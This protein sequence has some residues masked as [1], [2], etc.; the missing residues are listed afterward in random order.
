MDKQQTT[1]ALA[2]VKTAFPTF[3]RDIPPEDILSLW[4]EIFS[5]DQFDLVAMAVKQYIRVEKYPPTIADIRSIMADISLSGHA[6]PADL[7]TEVDRLMKSGIA[8][9]SDREAYEKMSPG[10]RA[11]TLAAGG[12]QALSLSAVDDVFTKKLFLSGATAYVEGER[13]RLM[14]GAGGALPQLGPGTER[15]ALDRG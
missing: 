9:D 6:T 2:I 15:A 4:S 13:K 7:W 10:C 1:A 8:P 12:W 14:T 3:G 11:A 5:D